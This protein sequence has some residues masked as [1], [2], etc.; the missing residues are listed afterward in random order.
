MDS[1][2]NREP[3]LAEA[4]AAKRRNMTD[5]FRNREREIKKPS[6]TRD[7]TKAELLELRKQMMKPKTQPV[8]PTQP[9]TAEDILMSR[10]IKGEKPNVSKKEMKQLTKKNYHQLPEVLKKR[11]ED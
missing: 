6:E 11:E 2:E 1:S 10:L 9:E 5:N 8:A 3:S 4:F 7:K